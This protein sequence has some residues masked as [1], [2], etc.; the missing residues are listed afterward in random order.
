MSIKSHL[1]KTVVFNTSNIH[2]FGVRTAIPISNLEAAIKQVTAALAALEQLTGSSK[3]LNHPL[4][5]L[6][7]ERIIHKKNLRSISRLQ[8]LL[9]LL[10][11]CKEHFQNYEIVYASTAELALILR[12]KRALVRVL[13]TRYEEIKNQ[14]TV[15]Y[16]AGSD[17]TFYVR[18][19]ET[20][21]VLS[22]QGDTLASSFII[23]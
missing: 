22:L 9:G 23:D 16:Q 5:L 7:N 10:S 4:P 19:R 6:L 1:L 17:R 2:P 8:G 11:Y 18:K 15:T 21:N 3:G 14:N 20:V 13:R 12:N